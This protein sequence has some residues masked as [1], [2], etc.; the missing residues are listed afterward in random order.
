MA[1]AVQV[2]VGGPAVQ[3]PR[4]GI[5]IHLA[6]HQPV[7]MSLVPALEPHEQRTENSHQCGCDQQQTYAQAVDGQRSNSRRE[8]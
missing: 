5:A 2:A 6:R 3:R 8:S 4:K 7:E 1:A